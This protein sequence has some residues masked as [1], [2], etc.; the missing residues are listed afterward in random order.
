MSLDDTK[1]LLSRKYLGKEGIHGIGISRSQ[2]AIRVH[3]IPAADATHA[4]R[5]QDLIQQMK[6][7]AGSHDVQVTTEDKPSAN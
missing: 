3:M 6:E 1:Q 5:Q 2:N 7:E 4:A